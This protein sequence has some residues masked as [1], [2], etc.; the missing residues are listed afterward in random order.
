VPMGGACKHLATGRFKGTG[1]RWNLETAE[2][3]LRV[4][5]ALLTNRRLDL[6]PY[7]REAVTAQVA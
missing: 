3:L 5:A 6:R 7:A 1:M 4:C 2:P